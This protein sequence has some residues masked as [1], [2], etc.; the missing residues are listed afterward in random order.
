MS[1]ACTA[2]PENARYEVDG[3]NCRT[4]WT[5]KMHGMNLKDQYS[6]YVLHFQVLQIGPSFP[7]IA[8]S[9]V[10][11][12]SFNFMSCIFTPRDFDGS[13][14]QV[15]HFQSTRLPSCAFRAAVMSNRHPPWNG[16]RAWWTYNISHSFS[17]YGRHAKFGRSKS[18][19]VRGYSGVKSLVTV[20]RG[21]SDLIDF[22][23]LK[24]W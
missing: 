20:V 22:L 13:H 3:Q 17:S 6:K 18:N 10:A 12:W 1:L 24:I 15:L 11:I 8:F 16:H 21:V 7:C 14:F 2:R 5:I 23:N 19:G 4:N 9:R